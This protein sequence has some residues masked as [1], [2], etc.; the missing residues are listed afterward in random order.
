MDLF[1]KFTYYVVAAA[2][3]MIAFLALIFFVGAQK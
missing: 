2:V 1:K 3:L